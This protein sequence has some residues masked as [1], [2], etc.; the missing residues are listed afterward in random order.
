M[1]V[2]R[3]S[4]RTAGPLVVVGALCA[5]GAMIPLEV[6]PA[7]YPGDAY[8]FDPAMYSGV[9]A[10]R[11]A[12]PMLTFGA[13]TFITVGFYSLY[14]RDRSV[15]LGWQQGAAQLTLFGS[16]AWLFGTSLVILTDPNDI[17]IGVFG[18][19]VTVLAL[20]IIVLGLL[21]WGIGYLRI[22][23]IRLGSA[24][25]GAPFLTAL[26]I[27]IS[28]AGIDFDPVGGLILAAPTAAMAVLI[29]YDLWVGATPRI[30]DQH[31]SS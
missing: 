1:I 29:G 12:V 20:L 13:N 28:L 2:W 19:L 30:S 8:V 18:G 6:W 22:G 26:Y 10:Q 7:P 24:L 17:I 25:T 3:P 31:P 23:Q 16:G 14:L 15:M 11:V 21:T 4:P 9:W 5:L 27:G